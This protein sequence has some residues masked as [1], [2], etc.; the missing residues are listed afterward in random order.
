MM[1]LYLTKD[2]GHAW[3]GSQKVRAKADTPSTV[4]NANDVIW[5]FFRRYTL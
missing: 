4:I 1:Q 5:D 3:P 2:G